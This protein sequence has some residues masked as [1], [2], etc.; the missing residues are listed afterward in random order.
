MEW[1]RMA[2][3]PLEWVSGSHGMR[4]RE[5]P[6]GARDDLSFPL[7]PFFCSFVRGARMYPE[8]CA[9][10]TAEGVGSLLSQYTGRGPDTGPFVR[11]FRTSLMLH[12]S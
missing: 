1:T 10:R 8:T 11:A 3:A 4:R 12:I 7:Y 6:R 9:Q 2:R 5:Q